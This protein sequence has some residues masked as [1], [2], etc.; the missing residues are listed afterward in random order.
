ML[1]MIMSTLNYPEKD[2]LVRQKLEEWQDMKFGLMMTWG[3]YSQ[4]GIVESWSL[5][6]EDYSWSQRTQ[7]KKPQNKWLN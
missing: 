6:P 7:G 1:F 4:W 5:S 2:P 3:P